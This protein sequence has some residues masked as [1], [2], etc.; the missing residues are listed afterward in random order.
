VADLSW[1][2][3]S[4]YAL[5]KVLVSPGNEVDLKKWVSF[6]LLIIYFLKSDSLSHYSFCGMWVSICITWGNTLGNYPFWDI[7]LWGCHNKVP[8]A[9]WLRKQKFIV[10]QFWG[11]VVQDWA[12]SR[13]GFF[14]G[15]LEKMYLHVS[16]SYF[17]GN[18]GHSLTSPQSLPPSSYVGLL[19]YI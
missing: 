4:M 10:S 14:W 6:K 18:L 5:V 2:T 8:Q 17:A 7:N 9:G 1:H 3:I 15:L 19:V 12:V 16:F 11:L 13:F